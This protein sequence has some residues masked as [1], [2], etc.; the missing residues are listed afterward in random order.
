MN[1]LKKNVM[2]TGDAAAKRFVSQPEQSQ[3]SPSCSAAATAHQVS[4]LTQLL[5]H[6]IAGRLV[7]SRPPITG[8]QGLPA[9]LAIKLVNYL[10]DERL[11]KP[12]I[13]SAFITWYNIVLLT[14]LECSIFMI[15]S[16]K[17]NYFA[18]FL[19]VLVNK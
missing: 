1:I 16:Y 3:S 17:R 7:S 2:F 9:D 6:H 14:C 11:L 18:Y 15:F 8:M 5:I 12:K 4:S 13:L 19:I 10:L